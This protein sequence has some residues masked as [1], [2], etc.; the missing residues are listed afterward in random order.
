MS[1]FTVKPPAA[2]LDDA[3]QAYTEILRSYT[4]EKEV[5]ASA[6]LGLAAIAENRR[7]FDVAGEWYDKVVADASLRQAY[8]DIAAGRKRMLAD[9]RKPYVLASTQPTQPTSM[10]STPP[11]F[12]LM[13]PAEPAS[14]PTTVVAATPTTAP[15]TQP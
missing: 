3:E 4:N 12:S 15:A 2:Y 10:P 9:L 8:R 14:M 5:A 6:L 7:N 13:R 11:A 1:G